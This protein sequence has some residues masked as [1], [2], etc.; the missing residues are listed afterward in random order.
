MI[1]SWEKWRYKNTTYLILS[2]VIFFYFIESSLVQAFLKGIGDL[3]YLG[4]FISGILFVSTFTAAP[5]SAILFDIAKLLNPYLVAISAGLGAV[6]GD[7]LLLRYL[8]DKV[9]KELKPLL[10]KPFQ[11]SIFGFLF[12]SP[13]FAWIIPIIGAIIIASPFPDEI[14]ISLMG[15]S[16]IK[17]WQFLLITFILNSM[18]IFIIIGLANS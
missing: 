3:G 12:S 9:F 16:R 10:K 6:V 17:K 13:F 4:S 11:S 1:K 2:L 5:A 15:L 7:Y 8:Q 14:G 18:G